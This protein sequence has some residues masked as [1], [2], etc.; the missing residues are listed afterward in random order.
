[1]VVQELL[2]ILQ[3]RLIQPPVISSVNSK[4]VCDITPLA[5]T[6][7]S[8]TAGASFAWTRAV[9]AG[10]SNA[11]GS[12]AAALINESLDNTTIAPVNVTYVI[13]PSI[14]GCPGT[15]FNLTVTV[16]PTAVI[17]SAATANICDF[18]AL[19]YTATSSTA[20]ATFAWTRAVVAG[21]SNLAGSG[22]TASIN[23][24][25][26]NTV[27]A[28]V[29][30]TYIITPS[31]GGCAGT[32]FNLVVTVNPTSVITSAATK[33]ICDNTP[34]AYTSTS[35]TVG[36]TFSWTRAVVAGIT[37][38]AGAGA[39]A[40]INES[41][42][43]NTTAAVNVI[44]VITPR[45]NGCDGTP[46]NLTV[47]VNPSPVI[48][49]AATKTVC[50]VTPLA[51]TATS[52]T[53]GATFAWT[54]AVVA[55]ISNGA[56]SGAVALINE[57][58][59]NTTTA[60]VN[61]T[62]IITPSYGGCAGTPFSLVV[63]VNP[64]A[65][66]TSAATAN[67][68]DNTPLG[69]TA[70]SSTAGATFA[71]TRAVVA[72]ITNGAGSGATAVIN[73]SLDNTTTAPVTVTYIITPGYAGCPGTA[74]TLTVTVNP[75]S[76]ITSANSKIVCSNSPIAYTATSSTAGAS[77]SWTRAVVAG[78]SNAAGCRSYISDK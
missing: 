62:Y 21:I 70:T 76:V 35:S 59:D 33:T 57:S 37:N 9:V 7:T 72:G 48:T 11:A 47:T 8:S 24:S 74:F 61:V 10:I 17:T 5:Y 1:M 68:C 19:G 58:L 64:T 25:L 52:S 56:G 31:Y 71:W 2:L 20:G 77:F 43:N 40:L 63:T 27:T 75:T 30:V 15:P 44:Y 46:F 39:T 54:R 67:V 12:G 53:G 3:L 34:L 73:E 69:Y 23:E 45:I 41:L 55:G 29:A 14:G 60:A 13:T 38:G 65:V 28:P 36:A 78:I 4:T 26:N 66:I 22:A 6:A 32:P 42:D 18:V 51:Y 49:S 16:N 50:D